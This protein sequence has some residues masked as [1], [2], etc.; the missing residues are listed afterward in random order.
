[1]HTKNYLLPIP[2]HRPL[3]KFI[4]CFLKILTLINDKYYIVQIEADYCDVYPPS[5][6]IEAPFTKEAL[7]LARNSTTLATSSGSP[8]LP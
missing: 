2:F 3:H 4:L 1:M 5:T 8:N 7:S 6:S